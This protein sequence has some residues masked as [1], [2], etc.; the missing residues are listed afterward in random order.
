[1]R[2]QSSPF[3][4][5]SWCWVETIVGGVF[6]P[7]LPVMAKV[8]TEAATLR[9]LQVGRCFTV[10]QTFCVTKWATLEVEQGLGVKQ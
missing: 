1:M 2:L 9:F 3:S 6:S 5:P 8:S 10:T 7:P 4:G